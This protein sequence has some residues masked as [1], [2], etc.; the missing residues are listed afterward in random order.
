MAALPAVVQR[1]PSSGI[2]PRTWQ[3]KALSQMQGWVGA[4]WSQ[5]LLGLEQSLPWLGAFGATC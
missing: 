1:G 4:A 3:P 5:G 2:S